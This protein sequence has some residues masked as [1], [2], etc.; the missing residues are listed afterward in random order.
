V[1][2]E[3][4]AEKVHVEEKVNARL[5]FKPQTEEEILREIVED[6]KLGCSSLRS[7]NFRK[8]ATLSI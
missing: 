4:E 6:K 5:L 1:F 2:A 8:D 3:V 7:S